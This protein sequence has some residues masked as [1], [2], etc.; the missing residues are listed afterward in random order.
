LGSPQLIGGKAPFG[1]GGGDAAQQALVA[2]MLPLLIADPGLQIAALALQQA[3][4][5]GRMRLVQFQLVVS[6]V[7]REYAS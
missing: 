2:A 6:V 4:A 7:T 3:L 1:E 5:G